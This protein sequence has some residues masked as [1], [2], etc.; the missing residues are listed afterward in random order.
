LQIVAK[1]FVA[2]ATIDDR[3]SVHDAELF[4]M[5]VAQARGQ[6]LHGNAAR[7]Q[8]F[9][10]PVLPGTPKDL[11]PLK[12][13]AQPSGDY[14]ARLA[15]FAKKKHKKDIPLYPWQQSDAKP[16]MDGY[17]PTREM[18]EIDVPAHKGKK[19]LPISGN[20][21]PEFEPPSPIFLDLTF[22]ARELLFRAFEDAEA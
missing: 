11:S 10:R 20:T 7:R 17:P 9:R 8:V 12:Q 3:Y 14:D 22:K 19:P 21:K 4:S 15:I 2:L 1:N 13:F 5:E 6:A 16:P 18:V